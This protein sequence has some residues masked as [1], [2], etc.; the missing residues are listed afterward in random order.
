MTFR[1]F[2]SVLRLFFRLSL[3]NQL[4]YR[5]SFVLAVVTKMLRMVVLLIFFEA[6]FLHVE[7]IGTWN[8][9]AVLTL[10]AV[11]LTFESLII[12][13]FH[14]NLA[15]YLPDLLRK[16][17]FDG[18]LVQ[19]MPVL[20]HVS[21]R[22]VDTMDLFSTLPI[23]ALWLYILRQGF[24]HPSVGDILLFLLASLLAIIFTFS[25]STIIAALSFWSLVPTGFGRIYENFLRMARYPTDVL[26]TT[27]GF[28]LTYI[29]PF[30]IV[31]TIPASALRSALSPAV[32]VWSS[33]SIVV[34]ALLARALWKRGLE[35]Y[36][37]ASS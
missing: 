2:T 35:R 37:S 17:T 11:Y 4:M 21:F 32:L 6:I 25:L 36:S 7:R 18:I 14:R 20:P 10:I 12:I 27:Q 15:Y 13:T 24:L 1:R 22:I 28:L 26:G 30:A 8:R 33:V 9:D 34:I 19:P 3:L 29:V 5:K 23:V 31:G 16:G